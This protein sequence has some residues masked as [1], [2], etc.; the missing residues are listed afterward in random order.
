MDDCVSG[1][2]TFDQALRITDELQVAVGKGGFTFKGFIMSGSDPPKHLSNNSKSVAVA[3]LKW[4]PKGDFLKFNISELNFTK[5]ERGRKAINNAGVIPE[6]L[7][8]RDCVS[9]TAEVFDPIGRVAPLLGTMKL[10]ISILHKRCLGRD[11]LI[12]VVD[13]EYQNNNENTKRTTKRGVC[14]IV[15]IHPVEEIRISA[16]LHDFVKNI[17]NNK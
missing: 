15:V 12:P 13:I 5:K 8:L 6:N 16:E 10:D 17:E 1:T 3:G 2:D 11:G 14:D 7:T 9:R 4:F